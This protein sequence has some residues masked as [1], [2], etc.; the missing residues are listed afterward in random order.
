MY[1]ITSSYLRNKAGS[2]EM[3]EI[4]GSCNEYTIKYTALH[5]SGD[6]DPYDEELTM[7]LDGD[8]LH[9]DGESVRYRC[10]RW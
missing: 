4:S 1:C 10:D 6:I 9:V 5:A 7:S 2:D 3:L 8:Q